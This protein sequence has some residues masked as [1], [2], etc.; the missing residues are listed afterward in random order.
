MK[1]ARIR[2]SFQRIR[3]G[4]IAGCVFVLMVSSACASSPA[5]QAAR[6]GSTSQG[7][8]DDWFKKAV[9]L[10]GQGRV[11]EALIWYQLA[12]EGKPGNG[13]Y[14]ARL[15]QHLLTKML[16]WPNAVRAYQRA[17]GLGFTQSWMWSQY[18]HALR[19]LGET[20]F[21]R[22]DWKDARGIFD[23]AVRVS[24]TAGVRTNVIP[25][26]QHMSVLSRQAPFAAT[27]TA[28]VRHRSLMILLEDTGRSGEP[29][30]R[31]KAK[32]AEL[33]RMSFDFMRH[34]VRTATSGLVFIEGEVAVFREP[35]NALVPLED[36]SLQLDAALASRHLGSILDSRAGEVD[37]IILIWA[38]DKHQTAHGGAT[39]YYLDAG[40]RSVWRGHVQI[41]SLRM[42]HNGPYL[43]CHEFFHVVENMCGIR[44]RHGFEAANRGS[45]PGWTGSD[46]FSYYGWSFSDNIPR[47]L[48]SPE[49]RALGWKHFRFTHK[50]PVKNE[51]Q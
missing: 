28:E 3:D 15:G 1:T 14:P 2:F 9:E 7:S 6:A 32:E 50:Y 18:A 45:F 26:L 41:P 11:A 35:V 21:S 17:I 5:A 47:I 19:W 24:Q 13:F 48:A 49:W 22:G 51:R 12:A 31:I 33:A 43:L 37:S 46:E 27:R 23:E 40:R 29:R 38:S 16:D 25:Y 44:P 4:L 34:W 10:D 39:R 30:R 36:G 20:A 8:A 42:A